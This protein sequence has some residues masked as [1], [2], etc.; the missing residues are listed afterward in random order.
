MKKYIIVTIF[1]V[2]ALTSSSCSSDDDGA[3]GSAVS[4]T[5][6]PDEIA[7]TAE[8][9]TYTIDVKT[10]GKGWTAYPSDTWMSLSLDGTT[11]NSGTVTL[12]VSANGGQGARSGIVVVRSGTVR[13][14][15]RVSQLANI[16]VTETSVYALSSG[17]TFNVGVSSQGS[18]T[19]SADVAW[20]KATASADAVSIEV[21][22]STA[23]KSR[24]GKVTVTSADGSQQIEVTQESAPDNSITTPEGY[25]LVWNDEFD[26]GT[27][28]NTTSW[29]HEEQGPGWVNNE[30]QTYVN[31]QA[32]GRRVTELSDGK[33]NINCFK[34]GSTIYSGRVYAN[35]GTGWK[36]GWFEARIKLPKGKGTWPAFWMMP[37]AGGQWPGCGEIDIMEEVG[38]DPGDV[39]ATIHCNKYNN[40]GTSIEHA[41]LNVPDA[42]DEF[43]VYACEWT[44]DNLKFY[45]DGKMILDY[46]NDGTGVDAWP[47]DQP[48]YVI[49]NL[50]WGGSWGGYK[51]TDDS[52]LPTTMKV[53]YV[54]VFQK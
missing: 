41:T 47:F 5:C 3:A 14:T 16:S 28:L 30:L 10:S 8:G 2:F 13:D 19:A 34:A 11:G 54:R 23:L 25:S 24:S 53:D 27:T 42:E 52:A 7:A 46:A 44:P 4:L 39:S 21:E 50:A 17:G 12:S 51:G 6:S 9:G 26:Q 22:P 31:G 43:H 15:V 37:V 29:T 20:I 45:V 49:L 32:A 33:L 36:Y 1:S 40:T 18:F 48:F 38:A 35:V